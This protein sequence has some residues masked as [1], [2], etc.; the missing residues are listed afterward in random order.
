MALESILIS[1]GN[2]RGGVGGTPLYRILHQEIPDGVS[3]LAKLEGGEPTGSIKD[4]AAEMIIK[5]LLEG[6]NRVVVRDGDVFTERRLEYREGLT[7]L[8]SSSG[9]YGVSLAHYCRLNGLPLQLVVPGN[10]PEGLLQK[11]RG[12][13]IEPIV[14][15]SVEGYH[16]ALAKVKEL[17]RQPS[18]LYVNQYDNLGNLHAHYDGTGREIW[19]PTQRKAT[20]FVAGVGTGGTLIGVAAYLK[21]QNP[22]IEAYSVHPDSDFPG[23]QGLQPLVD[24]EIH[25]NIFMAN[26]HLVDGGFGI[27]TDE[28]VK[29][30]NE[31]LDAGLEVGMSSGANLAGVVKLIRERNLTKGIIVTVL[32]DNF[33]RYKDMPHILKIV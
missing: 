29:Y 8:D 13:G 33:D 10:I 18:F 7:V 4:R 16:G 12:Y 21:E 23:I 3:V 6:N 11:I 5:E 9:N 26:R 24:G 17:A 30:W 14:T 19:E 31:L 2:R 15:G 25:S 20:H 22:R 1:E 28:V 32:P 27:T